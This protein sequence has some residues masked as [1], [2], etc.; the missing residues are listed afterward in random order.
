MEF[1]FSNVHTLS[2]AHPSLVPQESPPYS[3]KVKKGR[4]ISPLLGAWGKCNMQNL[5]FIY[6]N[7]Q[8]VRLII[9]D[10]N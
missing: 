9:Y 6:M 7:C 1:S 2:G 10:L 3:A 8:T 4:A 5:G